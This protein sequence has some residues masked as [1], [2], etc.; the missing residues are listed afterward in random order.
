MLWVNAGVELLLL[1][2]PAISMAENPSAEDRA[3]QFGKWGVQT[4]SAIDRDLS[5]ADRNL[6]A[7]KT[8][9][10]ERPTQLAFMWGAG[11][12]LSAL[13]AA[14]RF[15]AARRARMVP[16]GMTCSRRALR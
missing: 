1:L 8:T 2:V 13:A 10:G 7:E 3:A 6:Y 5:I 15:D 14:A 11:V 16:Y 12:Q 4:L 9:L